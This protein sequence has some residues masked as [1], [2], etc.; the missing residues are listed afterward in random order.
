MPSNR[1]AVRRDKGRGSEDLHISDLGACAM[2]AKSIKATRGIYRSRRVRPP[3]DKL[4]EML[5]N[6]TLSTLAAELRVS[7]HTI[8]NWLIMYGVKH[9]RSDYR[10]TSHEGRTQAEYDA[11]LWAYVR[12]PMGKPFG[13]DG[14]YNLGGLEMARGAV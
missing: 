11:Q 8:T 13:G 6:K 2:N 9:R 1:P 5:N 3:V 12:K 7:R 4:L 14:W 10:P